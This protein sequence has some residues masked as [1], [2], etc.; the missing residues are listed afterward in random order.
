MFPSRS[1]D[2]LPGTVDEE[3]FNELRN[4]FVDIRAYDEPCIGLTLM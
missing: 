4:G 1:E 2:G 3:S